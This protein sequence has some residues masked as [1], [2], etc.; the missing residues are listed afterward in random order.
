MQ[1]VFVL[2]LFVVFVFV[3]LAFVFVVLAFVFVVLAFV[4][5]VL[6]FVFVVLAFVFFGFCLCGFF[7]LRLYSHY[8]KFTSTLI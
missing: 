2:E 3:V 5:V 4:F 6:A 7:L 8:Y 1:I